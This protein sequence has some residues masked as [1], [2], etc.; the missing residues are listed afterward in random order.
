MRTIKFRGRVP[1]SDK[2]D[3]GRIVFG[4]LV[5]YDTGIYTHWIYRPNEDRNCPVEPE[6]VQQLINVD[7]NGREIYGNIIDGKIVL[8]ED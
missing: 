2:F 3:G 6:S 7:E 4:Y 8:S 1:G 5:V